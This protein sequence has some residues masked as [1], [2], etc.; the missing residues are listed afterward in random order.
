MIR[1]VTF[2]FSWW[3]LVWLCIQKFPHSNAGLVWQS[4]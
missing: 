3:A 1:H 4:H 2:G